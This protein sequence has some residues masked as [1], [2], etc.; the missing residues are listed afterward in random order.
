[1]KNRALQAVA[2]TLAVGGCDMF[3]GPQPVAGPRFT[4]VSDAGPVNFPDSLRNWLPKTESLDSWVMLARNV[5]GGFAGYYGNAGGFVL[6]FTDT[7]AAKSVLPQIK[8][9]LAL[10]DAM[11]AN[12]SLRQVKWN[13]AQ[14]YDWRYYSFSLLPVPTEDGDFLFVGVDLVGNRLESDVSSEAARSTVINALN[15]G[16]VPCNL[17]WTVVRTSSSPVSP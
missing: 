1:M 2:L 8:R 9:Q 3:T 7:T 6:S 13:F 16:L 14:L 15:A 12:A 11:W 17:V 5:P 4:C 10:P